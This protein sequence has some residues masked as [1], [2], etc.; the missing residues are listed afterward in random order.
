MP[1]LALEA[2]RSIRLLRCLALEAGRRGSLLSRVPDHRRHPRA[3][4]RLEAC[5]RVDRLPVSAGRGPGAGRKLQRLLLPHR[6][7]QRHGHADSFLPIVQGT[8]FQF[9]SR[10]QIDR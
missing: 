2:G 6:Q 3:E 7:L 9:A 10:H 8:K 5:R 4:D 1:G